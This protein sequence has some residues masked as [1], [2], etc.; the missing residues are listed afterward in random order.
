[1]ALLYTSTSAFSRAQGVGGYFYLVTTAS[2]HPRLLMGLLIRA[3]GSCVLRLGLRV[4]RS[5][6]IHV[7]LGYTDCVMQPPPPEVGLSL[8]PRSRE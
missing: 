2:G 6:K 1:M 5:E 7:T 4:A 3:F 8:L